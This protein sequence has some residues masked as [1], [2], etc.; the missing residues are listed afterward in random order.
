MAEF[1]KKSAFFRFLFFLCFIEL[2]CCTIVNAEKLASGVILADDKGRIIYA[3]NRDKLF[4]PASI[5]KILTSLAAINIL[6]ENYHFPTKYSFDNHSHDLWIKG[7]GEPLLISEVLKLLSAD[8]I[9]KTDSSRINHIILD[10]NFFSPQI[11]IPGQG[12]S[13]NPYD[14]RCKALSANFNTVNFQW[15]SGNNRFISGEPQT[16]LLDIFYSNIEK[17]G[18]KRGRVVLSNQHSSLYSGL[19]IK[20]FLEKNSIQVTGS[21]VPGAFPENNRYIHTFH[22]PFE[23]MDIVQKLLEY[24]NNFIAN[25]LLLTMGAKMYGEPATIEKGIEAVKHFLKNTFKNNFNWEE[26]KIHEGSGLSRSN[27][28]SPDQ[29][30]VILLKFMPYH[31]LLKRKKMDFYKTGTLLGV[32]TRAGY[33]VGRK[34]RLFPYVIMVNQKGVG[35][36]SILKHI[37]QR[38]SDI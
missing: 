20:H 21:V 33:I 25:Q 36:E 35:Y 22:S 30:L 6:G 15:D 18:L 12:R 28:I 34:N 16:P 38:V 1:R 32:R 4:V 7:Y 23:L 5:L 9:F 3:E 11:E 24:S 31:T 27:R 26:I 19:L 17:T 14:A 2:S 29:M 8:I 37:I 10:Q 13:L